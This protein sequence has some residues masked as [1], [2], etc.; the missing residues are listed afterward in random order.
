MMSS[1]PA[2]QYN[3]KHI[4]ICY[5]AEAKSKDKRSVNRRHRRSLNRKTEAMVDDTELWYSED[6]CAPSMSN[7]D[8]D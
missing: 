3:C 7:W 5:R 1:L 2:V 8:I 6:W 4:H